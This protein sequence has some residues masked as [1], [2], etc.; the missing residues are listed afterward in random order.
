MMQMENIAMTSQ[1]QLRCLVW[2]KKTTVWCCRFIQNN[3]RSIDSLK[4][5][6]NYWSVAARESFSWTRHFTAL[7]PVQVPG[8][9]AENTLPFPG[10]LKMFGVF[11]PSKRCAPLQHLYFTAKDILVSQLHPLF[12]SS[13]WDGADFKIKNTF[14]KH[15]LNSGLQSDSCKDWLPCKSIYKI[16]LSSVKNLIPLQLNGLET[17]PLFCATS[18]LLGVLL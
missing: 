13:S 12:T 18:T 3:K 14:I 7:A 11:I 9:L 1:L 8:S 6:K 16:V 5:Q 10:S 2:E 4:M 15:Y 17:S